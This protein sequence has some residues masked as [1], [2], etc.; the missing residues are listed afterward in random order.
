MKLEMTVKQ[1]IT[2][3]D[4]D[5]LQCTIG[6]G[7][8]VV[9]TGVTQSQVTL[10]V[11]NRYSLTIGINEH[12]HTFTNKNVELTSKR[13]TVG[14]KVVIVNPN[15]VYFGDV[16]ELTGANMYLPQVRLMYKHGLYNNSEIFNY[17]DIE[18]YDESTKYDGMI[19]FYDENDTV[20]KVAGRSY[21][22]SGVEYVEVTC[23]NVA[24]YTNL[25]VDMLWCYKDDTSDELVPLNSVYKLSRHHL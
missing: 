3:R 2:V 7:S 25:R 5:G 24:K 8:K 1:P 18:F 17:S 21:K 4:C 19:V 9:L 12:L 14:T 13:L 20:E 16:I 6:V 10:E 15:H 22:R 11:N 23:D